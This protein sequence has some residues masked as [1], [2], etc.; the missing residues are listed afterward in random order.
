MSGLVFLLNQNLRLS[1]DIINLLLVI[2][3]Y[4][5]MPKGAARRSGSTTFLKI[6]CAHAHRC[7]MRLHYLLLL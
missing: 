6:L 7:V 1:V 2:T 5:P 3:S 4:A